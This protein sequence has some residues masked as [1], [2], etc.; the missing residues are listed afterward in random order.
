MNRFKAN[1]LL[2]TAVLFL[3]GGAFVFAG[4]QRE[5]PNGPAPGAAAGQGAG[6]VTVAN[7]LATVTGQIQLVNLIHPVVKSGGNQY[8]LIVPR[9]DVYRAGV[10]EGQTITVKGYKVDGMQWGP[11][12][13]AAT[14]NTPKLLV[15]SATIDGKSYDLSAWADRF[16]LAVRNG[17]GN[18]PLAFYGH[19][20]R[21]RFDRGRPGW[22]GPG[23]GYGYGP[24]MGYGRGMG[25]GQGYGPG[26]GYGPGYGMYN[27]F[28]NQ[29]P[30]QGN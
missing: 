23:S 16:K 10:K 8:E 30:N 18:G 7:D 5:T 25:Y 3:A 1:L 27:Q 11:F 13:G 9:I 21:G 24:G 2:M 17:G 14:D 29:S 26:M 22:G 6:K 19:R 20:G 12:Y 15:S 4:G 28:Q